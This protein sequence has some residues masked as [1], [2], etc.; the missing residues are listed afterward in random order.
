MAAPACDFSP[1]WCS[2]DAQP[3]LLT[4]SAVCPG[5]IARQFRVQVQEHA[6]DVWRSVKN[7]TDAEQAEQDAAEWASR[8]YRVR[9][10]GYRTAPT[11][12]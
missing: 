7:C 12:A 10:I 1:A 8:G 4:I 11:A 5:G 3:Q 9:V 2:A 6:A